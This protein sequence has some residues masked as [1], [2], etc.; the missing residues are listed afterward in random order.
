MGRPDWVSKLR[1]W[2][3]D[4]VLE[5]PDDIAMCEFRCHKTECR[6]GEWETCERRLH[7][8]Y[9]ELRRRGQL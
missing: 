2:I 6:V 7:G 4:Q 5:V 3:D 9:P 1:Q 8:P